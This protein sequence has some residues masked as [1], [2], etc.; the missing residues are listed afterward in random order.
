MPP[1][2]QVER[3]VSSTSLKYQKG[4]HNPAPT[5]HWSDTN[6][7]TLTE[8]FN[9]TRTKTIAVNGTN[10]IEVE[11]DLVRL[12]FK[13]SE[14]A[15]DYMEAVRATLGALDVAR[16]TSRNI[17][18]TNDKMSC[19][20]MSVKQFN[21]DAKPGKKF[22]KSSLVYQPSIIL[23]IRLEG[24]SVSH[25]GKLMVTFL[26]LGI[27]NYEAP[28]YETTKLDSY[29]NKARVN[30][31]QNAKEKA[32]VILAGFETGL[33]ARNPI[34]I[35]DMH[36]NIISDSDK[37]FEGSPWYL[38]IPLKKSR[39]QDTD[40]KDSISTGDDS[41]SSPVCFDPDFLERTDDLFSVPPI[42]LSAYIKVIFEI[43]ENTD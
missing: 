11:P 22:K 40:S 8:I 10:E 13:V 15:G 14:Q 24:E 31:V 37:S 21:Q 42:C 25:F 20:S 7:E 41:S 17:G 35:N 1:P 3:R 2:R 26:K 32:N 4:S 29:R 30:A 9:Q 5:R 28:K 38:N 18:I 23:R 43:G 34:S 27:E 16:E 19:D 39:P 12:S 36:V 33:Y 6:Q